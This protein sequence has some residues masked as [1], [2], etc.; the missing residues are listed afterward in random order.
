M[1]LEC[2]AVVFV[3][4]III[5]VKADSIIIWNGCKNDGKQCNI[6]LETFRGNPEHDCRA[7]SSPTR[8]C[9]TNHEDM[10]KDSDIVVT[11]IYN[12]N[13]DVVLRWHSSSIHYDREDD[14]PSP[15]PYHHIVPEPEWDL[16]PIFWKRRKR[17]VKKFRGRLVT[18]SCTVRGGN[19]HTQTL[20][21]IHWPSFCGIFI[22]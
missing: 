9:S 15:T 20:D 19:I 21:W 22:C 17:H 18:C 16:Q 1:F 14:F 10:D 3:V 12:K 2:K 8:K 6:A 4:G 11:T 5:S 13:G 7:F